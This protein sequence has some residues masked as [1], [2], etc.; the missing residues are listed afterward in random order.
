MLFSHIITSQVWPVPC[1]ATPIIAH[2]N[3]A[4]FFGQQ[5]LRWFYVVGRVM[6]DRPRPMGVSPECSSYD[7]SSAMG[8]EISSPA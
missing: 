6:V 4:Q 5:D 1:N 7:S 2:L 8:A 3:A